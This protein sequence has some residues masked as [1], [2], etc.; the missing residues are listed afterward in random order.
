MDADADIHQDFLPRLKDH[1]L[2]RLTGQAKDGEVPEFSEHDRQQLVFVG[3]RIYKHQVLRIN[4]TT[5]DCRRS[6]DTI[7]PRTR[8]DI[9]V[10]SHDDDRDSGVE[11]FEPYW[12]ARVIG[13]FH[14]MVQLVGPQGPSKPQRMNFL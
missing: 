12:Y 6:Q 8:S 1:L 9:M 5:Y 13:I 2:A 11:H 4:Y 14:A 3:E 10:L 7:N